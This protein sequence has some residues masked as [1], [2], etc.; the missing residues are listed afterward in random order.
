MK[1]IVFDQKNIQNLKFDLIKPLTHFSL[2]YPNESFLIEKDRW[3]GSVTFWS[4]SQYGLKICPNLHDLAPRV[5]VGSLSF[6][7]VKAAKENDARIAL[8]KSFSQGTH[9]EKATIIEVDTKIESGIKITS[10]TSDYFLILPNVLPFT[11]AP[12][13]STYSLKYFEPEYSLDDYKFESYI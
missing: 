1:T 12:K 7:K 13:I 5:E 2:S 10:A 9:L 11:L 4:G 8:P 6:E 3:I